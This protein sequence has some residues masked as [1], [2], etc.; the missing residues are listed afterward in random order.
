MKNVRFLVASLV[1][2]FVLAGVAAHAVQPVADW[3][4]WFKVTDGKLFT[5]AHAQKAAGG[6][7]V[8][9]MVAVENRTG[10]LVRVAANLTKEAELNAPAKGWQT[11]PIDGGFRH[12]YKNFAVDANPGDNVRVWLKIAGADKPVSVVVSSLHYE[13]LFNKTAAQ[14]APGAKVGKVNGKLFKADGKEWLV[15]AADVDWNQTQKWLAGLGN[16][17]RM[18]TKDELVSLYKEVGQKSPIGMQFVW[19]EKRDAHSAWHFSFYYREVRWG[20][21]DDHSRYGSAVAVRNL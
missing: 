13:N 12:S 9:W 17:W 20:Y 2:V 7:G 21:F 14:P 1:A 11:W 5:R 15:G 4:G 16:G 3:N 6:Q 10:K 18:P 19:A 8:V